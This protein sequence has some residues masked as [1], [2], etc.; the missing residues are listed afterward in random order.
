MAVGSVTGVEVSNAVATGWLRGAAEVEVTIEATACGESVAMAVGFVTGEGSAEQ[1][2]SRRADN[3]S[4][5]RATVEA[6]LR[7]TVS[8]C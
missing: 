2:A 3:A 6:L 1:A 4:A 5:I 8:P 7:L